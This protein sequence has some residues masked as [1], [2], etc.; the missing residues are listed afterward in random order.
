MWRLCKQIKTELEGA[1]RP[2]RRLN[3][4]ATAASAEKVQ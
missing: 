4:H 1:P 3:G 2:G